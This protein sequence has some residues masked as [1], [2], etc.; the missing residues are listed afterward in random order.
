[1]LPV[2]FRRLPL[3][4]FGAALPL[5]LL[6]QAGQSQ[7]LPAAVEQIRESLPLKSFAFYLTDPSTR[8]SILEVGSSMRQNQFR[9]LEQG[10]PLKSGG[11][12]W[13]RFS[14][15]NNNLP[16]GEAGV[17]SSAAGRLLLRLGPDAPPAV[18]YLAE[19]VNQEG[20]IQQWRSYSL[21]PGEAFAL[22]EP[23][24]LPLTVYVR[25]ESVPSLWFH[26]LLLRQAGEREVPGGSWRLYL[27]LALAL[28]LLATLA[29]SLSEGGSW[30]L[31]GAGV[32]ACATV[33][34]IYRFTGV[35]NNLI[36]FKFVPQILAPGLAL[37]LMPHLGRCF[38]GGPLPRGL[39]Y[40][41]LGLSLPGAGIA[42]LPLLPGLGWASRLLP[43]APL[44]L[45][46]LLLLL[47][48]LL[49]GR[50][51]G[52]FCHFI[53]AL[54]P[55]AGALLGLCSLYAPAMLPFPEL[56]A[57][58]STLGYLACG[59]AMIL[60]TPSPAKEKTDFFPLHNYLD[61]FSP[62]LPEQS[63]EKSAEAAGPDSP[64]EKDAPWEEPAEA[65]PDRETEEILEDPEK[66]SPAGAWE[67]RLPAA[68]TEKPDL[69]KEQILYVDAEEPGLIILRPGSGDLHESGRDAGD[70][71]KLTPSPPGDA[72]KAGEAT[73]PAEK[74][75]PPPE[76]EHPFPLEFREYIVLAD[77]A[78]SGR[79]SLARRL[80]GLP[81][82]LVEAANALEVVRACAAQAVGLII[83][84]SDMP[85]SEIREALQRINPAGR[86]PVPA[87]GL[88]LHA[89]QNERMLRLG[90]VECLINSV[91]RTR[92]H[93]TVLRLCPYPEAALTEQD[94]LGP[95][96]T[97]SPGNA[98]GAGRKKWRVPLLDL[99]VSSL[100]DNAPD[101]EEEAPPQ[102]ERRDAA[103]SESPPPASE[104]GRCRLAGSQ[105]DYMN[106]E[107]LPH[108]PDF[109]I[110]LEDTL[111]DLDKA[112]LNRDL[113]TVR[114]LA[115]RM[116]EQ[117][118]AYGLES[119][120]NMAR[121]VEKAARAQ[122]QEAVSYIAEDL[123]TLG[124]RY[125]VSLNLTHVQ[126]SK[127]P[128]S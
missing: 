56:G 128:Q 118:E 94:M 101:G 104:A 127:Q 18:L 41:L 88:I 75:P 112:R 46:P 23:A 26:P 117:A 38:P 71:F 17:S 83:F 28:T 64:P 57:Q 25:L 70:I 123:S 87:L 73:P 37:I 3:L 107:M 32:L 65:Y 2:L 35:E 43:L 78:P 82:K 115:A 90:C 16:R 50:R 33:F 69:S 93:Q 11:A 36:L 66:A 77:P 54:F 126:H 62:P 9:S 72:E 125:L 5:F 100:D 102:A 96:K 84:D 1:M 22:P 85:E 63:P 89:S 42:L 67:N 122:D 40:A 116:I 49:A 12:L 4:A 7:A 111:E 19:K 10:I 39:D 29:R 14:L 31:W 27:S 48:P 51:S 108:I 99:I 53:F 13:L 103:G 15:V 79:R 74:A 30:R 20:E 119:L 124:K 114:Q 60:L 58:L 109:L 24:F 6:L 91:S 52:A 86:P 80:E 44:A 21:N 98:A 76:D 45:L 97:N 106:E 105:S 59:L 47:L 95:A 110:V 113:E 120:E 55:F 8:L 61:P 121:C 34:S 92:F 68:E 81:Y